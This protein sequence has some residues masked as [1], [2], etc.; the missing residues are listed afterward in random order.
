M[1]TIKLKTKKPKNVSRNKGFVATE[2][3]AA[4]GTHRKWKGLSSQSHHSSQLSHSDGHT[5]LVVVVVAV[6][7]RKW[8]G[9][10]LQSH[11]L[12]QVSHSDGHFR[13]VVVVVV[14]IVVVAAVV[15]SIVVLVMVVVVVV[16]V[17]V[18]AHLQNPGPRLPLSFV[19]SLPPTLNLSLFLGSKTSGSK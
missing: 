15:V 13:S 12:S 9:L 16:A 11:T 3:W 19:P 1:N 18:I 4:N 7:H 8:K 2:A 10:S 5:S 6:P 14:S 17:V